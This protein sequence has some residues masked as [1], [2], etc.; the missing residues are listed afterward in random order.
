MLDGG[1]ILVY[2]TVELLCIIAIAY[3]D[4]VCVEVL[5]YY[6]VEYKGF[7]PSKLVLRI[8]YMNRQVA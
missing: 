2:Y 7:F 8:R 6:C 1:E 4:F 5:Y 3:F